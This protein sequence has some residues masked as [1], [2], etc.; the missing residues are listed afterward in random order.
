MTQSSLR[1]YWGCAPRHNLFNDSIFYNIAY[2]KDN[3]TLEEVKKAARSA[4]I[5][6]FIEALPDGYDTTVGEEV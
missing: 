5:H 3:A 4:Q 1:C 6:D 2:G